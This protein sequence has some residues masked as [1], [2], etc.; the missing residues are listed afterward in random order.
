MTRRIHVHFSAKK[1]FSSYIFN[2]QLA[3]TMAV[4]NIDEKG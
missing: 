2:L 1:Q 4:V 3:T